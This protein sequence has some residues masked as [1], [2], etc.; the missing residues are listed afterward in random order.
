MQ[1]QVRFA[2]YRIEIKTDKGKDEIETAIQGLL[3]LRQ[4][5]WQ[6]QRD[7]GVKTYDLRALIDTI[8]LIEWQLG[9][10]ILGIR[11]RCDNTGS[12]RPEQV[13]IALGF[14]EYPELIHRTKLIL[15]T[16]QESGR[17]LPDVKQFRPISIIQSGGT[18]KLD[19]GFRSIRADELPA[20]LDLYKHLF[21]TDAPLPGEDR[22]RQ[23]GRKFS[24]IPRCICLSPSLIIVL[25]LHAFWL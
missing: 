11:L 20:L 22:F 10:C 23:S 12:G 15:E 9:N 24:L 3:S 25:S 6:H 7:T 4:L 17:L 19:V 2:E 5:P 21:D 14:S 1:A 18:I 8:L 13:A 16:V